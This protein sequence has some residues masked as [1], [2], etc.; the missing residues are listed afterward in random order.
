MYHSLSLSPLTLSHTLPHTHTLPH[1]LT[2]SPTLS[3]TLP[4]SKQTQDMQVSNHVHRNASLKAGISLVLV[5]SRIQGSVCNTFTV[6][7]H[8]NAHYMST[9]NMLSQNTEDNA[10]AGLVLHGNVHA[11]SERYLFVL[12]CVSVHYSL[13]WRILTPR[14]AR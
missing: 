3:H 13:S 1:S 7:I 2:H 11:E 6:V 8:Q 10:T 12:V 14:V 9:E 5:L 4:L